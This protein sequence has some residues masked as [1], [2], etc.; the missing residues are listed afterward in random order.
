MTASG[1]AP[2]GP[3]A[4]FELYGTDGTIFTSH[5]G[6]NPTVDD[7]VLAGRLGAKS[8]ERTP[9]PEHL[10]APPDDRDHRLPSFRLM[11]RRFA[12]GIRTGTSPAPNFLDGFRCQQVMDGIVESHRSGRVVRLDLSPV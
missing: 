3:G 7:V 2:F 8:L 5:G 1:G 10:Q 12:D 6:P 11:A 9:V 4:R